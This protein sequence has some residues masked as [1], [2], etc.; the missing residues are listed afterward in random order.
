MI[1]NL[2]DRIHIAGGVEMPGFGLGLYKAK[3]GEEVYRAVRFA[4]D[5]GYKHI[6]TARSEERRVGKECRL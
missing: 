5:A 3:A 1:R 2:Q 6:D 4:L